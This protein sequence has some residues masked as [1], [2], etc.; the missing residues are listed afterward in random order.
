M[1]LRNFAGFCMLALGG[2]AVSLK[3]QYW[4]YYG[5]DS[6]GNF[7]RCRMGVDTNGN[8]RRD[9]DGTYWNYVTGPDYYDEHGFD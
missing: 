9:R 7:G 3:Q 1:T 4:H 8:C 6:D 2:S 5:F